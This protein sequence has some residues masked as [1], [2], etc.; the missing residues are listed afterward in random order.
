[1]GPALLAC[2][3]G[4]SVRN[5]AFMIAATLVTLNPED[6]QSCELAERVLYDGVAEVLADVA[7]V[8]EGHPLSEWVVEEYLKLRSQE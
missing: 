7:G 6:P 5:L 4:M 2:Q 8:P 3:S 1:M